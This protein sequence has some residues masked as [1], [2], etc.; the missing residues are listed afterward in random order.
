MFSFFLE[1]FLLVAG[2]PCC[3]A[4]SANVSLLT[5]DAKAQVSLGLSGAWIVGST[6][7]SGPTVFYDQ[8]SETSGT[9]SFS[10]AIS[11]SERFQLGA[12][13]PLIWR[14]VERSRNRASSTG[15]GDLK[16]NLGYEVLPELYYS[17]WR[18]KGFLYFFTQIPTGSSKNESASFLHEDAFGRGF[19]ALGLGTLFLKRWKNI[20]ASASFEIRYSIPRSFEQNSIETRYSPGFGGSSSFAAGYTFG[21]SGFRTGLRV[22]PNIEGPEEYRSDFFSGERSYRMVWDTSAEATYSVSG[23]TS[24]GISYSDQTLLGPTKNT[25][26]TRAVAMSF[27]YSW[28]R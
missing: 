23:N 13:L 11:V 26:L 4:G 18:P 22:G 5:S 10:G 15:I 25:D 8:T 12:N 7:E 1:A 17:A 27:S 19:F 28:D 3:S 6:P 14:S 21:R 20:D 9:S 16:L 2:G 24:I